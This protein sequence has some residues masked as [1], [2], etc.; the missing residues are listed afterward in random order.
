CSVGF[1]GAPPTRAAGSPDDDPTG[2]AAD[3]LPA[4]HEAVD[5][6]DPADPE[7]RLLLRPAATTTPMIATMSSGT[8]SQSHARVDRRLPVTSDGR[9][10]EGGATGTRT[11]GGRAPPFADAER[12]AGPVPAP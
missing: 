8:A 9:C 6:L 12:G 1:D 11:A 2:G 10:S 5:D 3:V 7:F 4:K